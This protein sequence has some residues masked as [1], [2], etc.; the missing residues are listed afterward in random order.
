MKHRF[1]SADAITITSGTISTHG[2][3][4]RTIHQACAEVDTATGFVQVMDSAVEWPARPARA[5]GFAAADSRVAAPMPQVDF[6]VAGLSEAQD[7]MVVG[8]MAGK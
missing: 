3:Q 7:F 6:M 8:A 5:Q 1:I 4:G 2:A